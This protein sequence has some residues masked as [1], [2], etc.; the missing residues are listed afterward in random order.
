MICLCGA[1]MTDDVPKG[2]KSETTVGSKP[3]LFCW[4]CSEDPR[5]Q[6]ND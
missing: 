2:L 4:N 6:K 3:V 1:I 5:Y